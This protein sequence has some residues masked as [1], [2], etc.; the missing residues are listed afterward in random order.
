MKKYYQ[1]LGLEE[2]ATFEEVEKQYSELLKEFDPEKQSDDNLKES[3]N[4]LFNI[5]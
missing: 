4:D 5:L 3:M 2:G 1:I